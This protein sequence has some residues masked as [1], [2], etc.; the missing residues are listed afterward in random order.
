MIPYLKAFKHW[1]ET[2]I[3]KRIIR[4]VGSIFKTS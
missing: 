3:T 2:D 1:M 4:S